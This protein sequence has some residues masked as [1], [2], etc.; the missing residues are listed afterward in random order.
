MDDIMEIEIIMDDP[1]YLYRSADISFVMVVWSTY[2]QSSCPV[3]QA[4]ALMRDAK[5]IRL[6]PFR[7]SMGWDGYRCFRQGDRPVQRTAF[8]PQRWILA[9]I[10]VAVA[11]SSAY[12][13]VLF[14]EGDNLFAF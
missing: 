5:T 4:Q 12:P 14:A 8:V 7:G 9:S 1:F 13:P 2:S 11:R 10:F 6:P 3:M